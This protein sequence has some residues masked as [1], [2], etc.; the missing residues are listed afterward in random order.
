MS[1]QQM[2][3]E[4]PCQLVDIY[5]L[6]ATLYDLVTGKPP[7][8]TGNIALQ[9][10]EMPVEGI[11]ARRFKLGVKGDEIPSAWEETIVACLAK[12]PEERRRALR[13]PHLAGRLR[14]LRTYRAGHADP[15]GKGAR[16]SSIETGAP[17][18]PAGESVR[19][20]R[21]AGAISRMHSLAA[22]S[23]SCRCA[24]RARVRRVATKLGDSIKSF[25][26]G[27]NPSSSPAKSREK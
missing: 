10:R 20:V 7:F 11:A 19:R 18:V 27:G 17:F 22:K 21:R 2:L 9:V 5:A 4:T 6:G 16:H 1:P 12:R 8:H 26:S 25:F 3:G 24:G 23:A 13:A 14:S 15:R